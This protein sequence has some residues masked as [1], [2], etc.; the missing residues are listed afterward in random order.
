MDLINT[1]RGLG[2]VVLRFSE[3]AKVRLSLETA[4]HALEITFLLTI[5]YSFHS[6]T[7]LHLQC[8]SS[9]STDDWACWI[10]TARDGTSTATC[11]SL[12]TTTAATVAIT[13]DTLASLRDEMALLL[14]EANSK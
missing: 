11:T 1:N 2:L 12:L 9:L 10:Q 4:R 7:A 6:A 13:T 3:V 8:D 5:S 14:K